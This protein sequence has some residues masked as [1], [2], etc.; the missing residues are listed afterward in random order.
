LIAA[1]AN[2]SKMAKAALDESKKI[3]GRY[4]VDVLEGEMTW[5]SRVIDEDRKK[6]KR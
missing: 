3:L 4:K 5:A 6:Q 2:K 1:D